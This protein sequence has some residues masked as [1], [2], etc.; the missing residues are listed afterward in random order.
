MTTPPRHWP[1]AGGNSFFLFPQ[2][3]PLPRVDEVEDEL[4]KRRRLEAV[5]FVSREPLTSRK[6]SQ[7]ANL[8]DGTEARTLVRRL[9]E[10]YDETGRAFRIEEIA[11]GYRLMTRRRFATWL[12]RLPDT[13]AEVRLS[14]PGMETLA[15]V[16]YQQPVLRADIEAIRGVNCGEILRQLMERE[17]VRICGRSEELGRPYLYATTRRFLELFGLRNLDM[18]P[19]VDMLRDEEDPENTTANVE[20]TSTSCAEEG[21][22]EEPE[23]SVSIETVLQPAPADRDELAASVAEPRQ[24][25]DEDD[26]DDDIDDDDDDEDDEDD[27]SYDEFDEEEFDDEDDG[28]DDDEDDDFDD[29]EWEEVDDD[30]DEDDGDEDDEDEAEEWDDE[31]WSSDDDDDD[32]DG[33]DV[34][35]VED[36]EEGV[37]E[38]DEDDDDGDDDDGDDDDGDDDDDGEDDDDGDDDDGDDDDDEDW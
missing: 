19:R 18:L 10:E 28:D 11:G 37:E 3:E 22:R 33:D 31:E 4:S 27:E 26:F 12:R 29:G 34:D 2:R 7:F 15:V 25:F 1:V 20:S 32:K 9:N 5:L 21:Q 6:L 38:L 17:L 8:A 14:A 36:D 30:G 13:P 16:A 23:V 35:E 24:D